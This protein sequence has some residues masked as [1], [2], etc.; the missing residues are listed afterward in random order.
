[1]SRLIIVAV[2]AV[3]LDVFALIDLRFIDRTRIRTFNKLVWALIIILV[4]IVGALL[5]FFIGRSSGGRGI[6]R[7]PARKPVAPD[8]DPA[9]LR[10][11]RE[12]QEAAE[13]IRRL[14]Q[15]LADL[16]GDPDAG[17]DASAARGDTPPPGAADA[18]NGPPDPAPGDGP[19]GR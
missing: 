16:E 18:E 10:R 7:R 17:G 9:F 19:P 13:R 6:S 4:P 5:W 3:I 14:E 15:E 12:E 8:D 1:M 2:A 11:I